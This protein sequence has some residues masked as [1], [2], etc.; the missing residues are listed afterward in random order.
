M[1]DKIQSVIKSF[2]SS[3]SGLDI[4]DLAFLIKEICEDKLKEE[5]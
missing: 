4:Y 3:Y 1:I 2:E 5:K